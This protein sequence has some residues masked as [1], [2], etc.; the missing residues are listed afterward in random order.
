MTLLAGNINSS[1]IVEEI[2]LEKNTERRLEAL[3]LTDGTKIKIL[4]KK[5]HGA[6]IFKVR[7]TRLAIGSEIAA[8][9]IVTEAK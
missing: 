4:N 5:K 6:V 3:G 7:G 8:S 1:Y 9:I 2:R